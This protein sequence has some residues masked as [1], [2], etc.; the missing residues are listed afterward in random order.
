MTP[1]QWPEPNPMTLH[2]ESAAATVRGTGPTT[3]RYYNALLGYL[4]ALNH[5]R[6]VS[7]PD[8]VHRKPPA[9]VV[10]DVMTEAVVAAHEGA[11]FKE[12]VAALARN[13]IRAACSCASWAPQTAATRAP[14]WASSSPAAAP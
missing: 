3:E 9:T 6:S 12:I 7:H 1:S 10:G 11:A 2:D 14:T 13:K 5:D 8:T 4:A